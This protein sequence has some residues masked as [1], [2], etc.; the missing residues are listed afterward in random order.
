MLNLLIYYIESDNLNRASSAIC[1]HNGLLVIDNAT[2]GFDLHELETG[3][4]IR[5]FVTPPPLKKVLKQIGIG[6]SGRVI[7]T[8]SD[9][10]YLY[11]FDKDTGQRIAALKH[12]KKGLVQILTVSF[13]SPS[14]KIRNL[15]P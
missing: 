14:S 12:L 2:N 6:L 7:M 3:A 13:D 11:I 8:G 4:Y 10:G 5:T 1:Y 9:H 15:Q